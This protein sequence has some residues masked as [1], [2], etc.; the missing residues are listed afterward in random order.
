[1]AYIAVLFSTL[2][3]RGYTIKDDMFLL[4]HETM[5]MLLGIEMLPIPKLWQLDLIVLGV[6]LGQMNLAYSRIGL[7]ISDSR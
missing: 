2:A 6:L 4:V 1:L 7:A 3:R 5:G